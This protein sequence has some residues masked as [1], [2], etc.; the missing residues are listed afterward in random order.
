[1]YAGTQA[2]RLLNVDPSTLRYCLEG[3]AGRAGKVHLPVIRRE[4]KGTG[5]AVTWAEFVEA[6][7]L[8]QYRRELQVPPPELRTFIDLLRVQFDV[9]YPLADQRPLAS[10]W[11]LVRKAQDAAGLPGELCLVTVT[12]GQLL[13]TAASDSF[14]R[15]ARWEDEIATGWRPH[16]GGW[17]RVA[18][19]RPAGLQRPAGG[20]AG[21]V[22]PPGAGRKWRGLSLSGAG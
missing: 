11:A 15:R 14:L 6:G 1:M 3:K 17:P 20:G 12:S 21:T 16:E 22:R 9:P 2:A 7:L 13:L 5:V 4:L 19:R 10:G 8:R 18:G